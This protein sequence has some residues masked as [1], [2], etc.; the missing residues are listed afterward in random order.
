MNPLLDP[1][2]FPDY[3]AIQP[4]HAEPAVREQIAHNR[5][6]LQG[7]LQQTPPT[8]AS[9]VEPFEALQARLG[10]VFAPVA[11][12]NSVQS[13]PALRQAYN[14][15]LEALTEYQSEVGQ[16]TALA[17]AYA[18]ILAQEGDRLP[19][20]AR[21][22][23][24][25]ALREFE[26]AG[27]RLA[28]APKAR[29]R[30]IMQELSQ[31]QSRFE[32]QVLDSTQAFSRWIEDAAWL[33]GLPAHVVE[34]AQALAAA[35]GRTGWVLKLDQPTYLAVVTHAD[36]SDLRREFYEAWTTRASDQGP[37]AGQHDNGPVMSQI[38]ALRQELAGLLGFA[39]YADLSLATKMARSVTEVIDFLEALAARYRPAA[40]VEFEALSAYAG[41]TLNA[42]DV[43]YYADRLRRERHDVSEEALRP[44]FPLPK[45]LAGL[46][47]LIERLYGIS[48]VPR[49]DVALWHPDASYLDLKDASGRLI[50]GLYTDYYARDGKRAG[51][52][53][54]EIANR[55]RVHGESRR[56]VANVVCNFSPPSGS[57]PALLRHSD[58]VT[59]FHEF[60]HA[61]HHLLTEIDLPSLAGINGVPWDVVE[62]P[63]QI[64]E[65]WAWRAEVIPL[66]SAHVE[67]GTPLPTEQL[68]RLLAT[69]TFHAGL[70]AVRQLEFA[71]FDFKLHADPATVSVPAVQQLLDSVRRSVGV[72]PAPPFNRFQHG[73]MHIFSGGYAAGYYSYKW[74]EVLAADA[75]AAF[76][77]AGVFDT[78]TAQR[79]RQTILSKGG[80]C[81]HMQAF[82]E[83]RGHRPDVE[84]LLRQDGLAA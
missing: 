28:D 27:V 32:E 38:L 61:L 20:S 5:S 51:A 6:A 78:A 11:H 14:A 22:V 77:K 41:R 64:M 30:A 15:C 42:W 69:R 9:L 55:Q 46:Y 71:L 13:S 19:E 12:L 65:Q 73:F 24:A 36:H 44:W 39:S 23:V 29:Y 81:D 56:P 66:I 63:S 16:N 47:G 7:L 10:R 82:I 45:V 26:L 25:H 18:A 52:W 4:E 76:A 34:R 48:I 50:G 33:E 40:L 59:L 43:A 74:A 67:D 31:L 80:A 35:E 17:E 70:A 8:F 57:Q 84:S 21:R 58:V 49:T 68:Q 2:E 72:I 83:F 62:L 79:F 37:D 75:F 53:M 54:G 60:G 1:T 3:A